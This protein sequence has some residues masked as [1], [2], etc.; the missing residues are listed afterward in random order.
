MAIVKRVFVLSRYAWQITK[1]NLSIG[2]ELDLKSRS[3]SSRSSNSSGRPKSLKI[4][5]FLVN[6]SHRWVEDQ[7][8]QTVFNLAGLGLQNHWACQTLIKKKRDGE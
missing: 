8:N 7:S 4:F 6:G 3:S 2:Q 5:A 1:E